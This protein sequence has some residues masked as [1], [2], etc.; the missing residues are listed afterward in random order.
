MGIDTA[1]AAKAEGA[2]SK[3]K[4]LAELIGLLQ[5]ASGAVSAGRR[6]V[7]SPGGGPSV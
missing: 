2:R 1:V 6:R 3:V 7:A 5:E 4:R